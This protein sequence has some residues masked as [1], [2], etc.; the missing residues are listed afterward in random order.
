METRLLTEHWE[1]ENRTSLSGYRE[2]GGYDGWNKAFTMERSVL[3][4]EIESSNL[5]ERDWTSRCLREQWSTLPAERSTTYLVA[6]GYEAEPGVFKDR[7][8]LR[9]DPHAVLEGIAIAARAVSA[10]QAFLVVR[11][12]F[13]EERAGLQKALDELNASGLLGE[14]PVVNIHLCV[15]GEG[16]VPGEPSSLVSALEG[17]KG[18]PR[19]SPPLLTEQGLWEQPTVVHNVETLATLPWIL[20]KGGVAY[21]GF[22]TSRSSGTR[23]ISV[24]G[25]VRNPG[26][27]EVE[28]GISFKRFLRE[29][30]GWMKEGRRLLGVL[31]G[32]LSSPPLGID[33]IERVLLCFESIE[34]FGSSLGSAGL[35]V[36]PYDSSALEV[37]ESMTQFYQHSSCGQC[38]PCREGTYWLAQ[39]SQKLR[40][41]DGGSYDF[42]MLQEVCQSMQGQGI[43]PLPSRAARTTTNFL[44]VFS[45]DFQD[46]V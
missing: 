5:R 12:A 2:H 34:N 39:L 13:V 21:T 29:D 6:D 17:K 32:G 27:F 44:R 22:G 37:L 30:V 40:E 4:Q 42:K 23:L 26:V 19:L 7:T 36:L 33:E 28:M 11:K 41:G 1:Q 45:Q 8:L 20:R 16:L 18:W 9:R 46:Y 15:V 38:S 24:S 10:R 3:R 14:N 43:C 35:I 25:P 31:P